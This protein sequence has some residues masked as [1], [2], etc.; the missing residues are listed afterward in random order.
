MTQ[1][2]IQI[3]SVR[4]Y[5]QTPED[6]LASFRKVSQAGYRIIQIQWIA[7]EVP[8]EFIRDALA[9]TGLQCVGT[10]DYYDEVAGQW[11]RFVRMN[12]L[13]GGTDVCLSG[14]PERWRS[15]E[16]C[17]ALADDLNE[18]AGR[19]TA[20][21]MRVSWHPRASD[22]FQLDGVNSLELILQRTRPEVH[23]VLDLYQVVKAG[24]NPVDWIW[25]VQ[26]RCELVHFKDYKRTESGEVLTPVGQGCIDWLPIFRACQE[27]GVRVGFAEQE[28]WQK[29]P[30][31]CLKES[32]DY[33]QA[34]LS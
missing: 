31:E 1:I 34:H 11:Q 27:S 17:L 9:E 30:F 19:L 26:G 18:R 5:L 21:G 14:I 6:V 12:E 10:Q 3:S 4:K 16:G 24:Y 15:Y 13:W 28:S 33:I 20:Q 7:P 25:R 2:G 22:A 23:F 29:D 32:Y 8:L